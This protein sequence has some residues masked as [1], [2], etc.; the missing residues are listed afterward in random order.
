MTVKNLHLAFS[1]LTIT[2]V[3]LAYGLAPDRFLQVLFDFTLESVDF[4]NLLK[5]NMGLY[6]GMA[7]YWLLGIFNP[8]HWQSATLTCTLFMGGLAAGRTIS[9]IADGIPSAAYVLGLLAEVTLMLWGVFNLK[10]VK[11][12]PR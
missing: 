6:L 7:I 9:L 1:A 2:I 8:E 12:Q 4:R 5:A 3:G 10:K 11:T